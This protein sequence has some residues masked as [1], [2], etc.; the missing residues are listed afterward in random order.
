[1]IPA[2]YSHIP[3]G[4]LMGHWVLCGY[5]LSITRKFLT[6]NIMTIFTLCR[7]ALGGGLYGNQA[8]AEVCL[9]G[10]LYSHKVLTPGLTCTEG[11]PLVS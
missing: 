3:S 4:Y 9:V 11:L 8:L 6:K 10:A 1:M 2:G 5:P 7:K